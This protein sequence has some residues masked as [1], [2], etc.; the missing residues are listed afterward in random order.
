[1]KTPVFSAV[2]TAACRP[3]QSLIRCSDSAQ[4]DAGDE[5][6]R[7]C[8]IPDR[9]LAKWQ[10]MVDTSAQLADVPVALIM[11][12]VDINIQVLVSSHS[13]GNPYNPGDSGPLE[14]SGAYCERVVRTGERLLVPNALASTDWKNNLDTELSMISYLGLPILWPN[15]KA[16]GTICVLDS[17]ENLYSSLFERVL[18]QFRD[19]IEEHLAYIYL[20]SG[21]DSQSSFEVRSKDEALRTS[22][23]RLR[24]MVESVT[25]EFLVH[26]DSGKILEINQQACFDMGHTR[27]RL[28]GADVRQLPIRF[29]DDW[30]PQRWAPAQ[31]GD[32]TIVRATRHDRKDGVR[33]LEAR[34]SCQIVE[35]RK[36]FLGLIRDVTEQI[37]SPRA[38]DA[39]VDAGADDT[40][41]GPRNNWRWDVAA[42][43]FSGADDYLRIVGKNVGA[44]SFS[45]EEF[46]E[47]VYP[48]DRAAVRRTLLEAAESSVSFRFECRVASPNGLLLYI[49]CVGMP[50]NATP[51]SERFIGTFNEITSVKQAEDAISET[52]ALLSPAIRWAAIGELAASVVHEVNQPLGVIANYAGAIKNWLDCPKP[53]VCEACDAASGLTEA[54]MC[55][56]EIVSGLKAVARTP[57][58]RLSNVGVTAAAREILTL[59]RHEF[60]RRSV[61]LH[62]RL[63]SDD[64]VVCCDRTLLQQVLLNLLRNALH[65]ASS[66]VGSKCQVWFSCERAETGELEVTVAVNGSGL[67]E[68]DNV[69]MFNPLP[70]G[71]MGEMGTGLYVCRTIVDA[72]GGRLWV[73]PRPARGT[74]IRFVLPGEKATS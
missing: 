61:G 58:L 3:E 12:V 63:P 1:M 15:R 2:H 37:T 5:Y 8:V 33:I 62:T 29:D 53:D 47:D 60:E 26:D 41:T 73:E 18:H 52:Y 51:G 25:D 69:A 10:T 31:A 59:V 57:S 74:T 67:N 39:C 48:A 66:D 13:V 17:K 9:L 30:N 19:I 21:I 71:R 35:A 49:E 11:R 16:F 46:L 23:E 42:K 50:D 54:A 45:F 34:F 20:G 14:A 56:G 72:H 44:S 32:T 36:I 68:A 27:D 6:I 22:T 70:V 55:A 65:S 64:V 28:L 4:S 43:Q 38:L 40:Q 7:S 24:F